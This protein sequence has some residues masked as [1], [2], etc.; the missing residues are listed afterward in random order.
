M[1]AK[2]THRKARPKARERGCAF[3]FGYNRSAK[4]VIPIKLCK[5]FHIRDFS[6]HQEKVSKVWSSISPIHTAPGRRGS[7]STQTSLSDNT[8]PKALISLLLHLDSSRR[9]R[10]SS[11]DDQERNSISPLL[12]QSFSNIFANIAFA[13]GLCIFLKHINNFKKSR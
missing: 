5:F 6:A 1:H 9:Y 13:I 8:F 7:W 12:Q 11:I 2:P 10:P 3:R 4:V